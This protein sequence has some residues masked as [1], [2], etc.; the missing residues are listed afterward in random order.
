[1]GGER[2]LNLHGDLSVSLFKLRKRNGEVLAVEWRGCGQRL[3]EDLP[4]LRLCVPEGSTDQR[5]TKGGGENDDVHWRGLALPTEAGR[6]SGDRGMSARHHG[7]AF[8]VSSSHHR[9]KAGAY[10]MALRVL[11]IAFSVNPT[12]V[13]VLHSL[14]E[15]YILLENAQKAY[16]AGT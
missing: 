12:A 13:P 1:M 10:Y 14:R 9:G 16:L 7:I 8:P 11:S 4:S 6:N 2:L 5:I 15:I 3:I